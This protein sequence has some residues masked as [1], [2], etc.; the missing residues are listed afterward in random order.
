MYRSTFG[1]VAFRFNAL[2]QSYHFRP[3]R[4]NLE[5]H[6]NDLVNY[7]L[8]ATTGYANVDLEC[9]MYACMVIQQMIP[10]EKVN[11]PFYVNV[12]FL[13]RCIHCNLLVLPFFLAREA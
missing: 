5:N 2:T 4:R 7:G 1:S 12:F 8:G 6:L 10:S 9:A 13:A 11:C 3:S